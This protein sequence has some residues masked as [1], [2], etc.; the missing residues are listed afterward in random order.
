[1]NLRGR[2]NALERRAR[3]GGYLTGEPSCPACGAPGPDPVSMIFLDEGVELRC[4][5]ECKHPIDGSGHPYGEVVV[6]V[7]MELHDAPSGLC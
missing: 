7:V 2:L 3:E 5:S 6:V 4:C 1:M